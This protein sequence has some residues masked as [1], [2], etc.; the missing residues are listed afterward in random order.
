[1]CALHI[2]PEP[3]DLSGSGSSITEPPSVNHTLT[4][5]EKKLLERERQKKEREK[6]RE[7]KRLETKKRKEQMRLKRLEEK[8]RRRQEKLLREL[9][10]IEAPTDST[11]PSTESISPTDDLDSGGL[12]RELPSIELSLNRTLSRKEKKIL[13]R[14]RQKKEREKEREKKRLERKKVKEMLRLQRLE[15]KERRRYEKLLSELPTIETPTLSQEERER[16][17]KIEEKEKNRQEKLE[18]KEGT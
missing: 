13:E 5:K 1:M 7:I 4:R 16:L 15:E 17:R 8:E 12:M 14:E 3:D 11:D 6:E 10:T 18:R 9:T 2:F